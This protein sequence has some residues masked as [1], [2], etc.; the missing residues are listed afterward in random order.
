LDETEAWRPVVGYEGWYEVSD[1]G[2]V[3]RVR[4]GRRTQPGRF[5]SPRIDARGYRVVYLTRA[6][7]T[8]TFMVHTLVLEA[9]V[10]PRVSGHEPDHINH[11]RHDNRQGNLRWRPRSQNRADVDRTGY[12]RGEARPGHKLTEDDVR[13]IRASTE[14]LRVLAEHYGV[15]HT[16]I[17]AIRRREKWGHVT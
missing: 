13:A 8:R 5:L 2:R 9:F 12:A 1:L 14:T 4:R 17:L 6:S 15:H 7:A 16:T 11:V 3:K 10:G